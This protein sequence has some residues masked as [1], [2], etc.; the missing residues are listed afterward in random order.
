MNEVNYQEDINHFIE[1][2]S[3]DKD[4]DLTTFYN[5]LKTLGVK[6]GKSEYFNMGY[7][8]GTNEIFFD[9]V[10]IYK[11]AIYHELFHVASYKTVGDDALSGLNVWNIKTHMTKGL[12]LNEGYTEILNNRYF[13]IGDG[14]PLQRIYIERLEQIIDPEVIKKAYFASDLAMLI[15][16]L[17]KYAPIDK[18]NKFISNLDIYTIHMN[19]NVKDRRF[20]HEE[21]QRGI[22]YCSCFL[23]A[24]YIQKMIWEQPED[25]KNKVFDF[26]GSFDRGMHYSNDPD[27]HLDIPPTIGYKILKSAGFMEEGETR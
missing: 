1:V 20:T 6:T 21:V 12:G 26:F 23:G 4:I 3:Q 19:P 10:E 11:K 5:N 13:N 7:D 8:S 25:I 24:V 27:I 2:V 18:I 16:E 17:G 14:Y 15:R 9:D 22:T